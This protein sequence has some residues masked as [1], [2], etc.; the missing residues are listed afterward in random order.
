MTVQNKSWEQVG[1]SLEM[2]GTQLRRQIDHTRTVTDGD[3]AAFDKAVHALL[4]ALDDSI[5]A[6]SRLARDPV[7][8]EDLTEFGSSVR[9]A[10]VATFEGARDHVSTTVERTK[11]HL[12]AKEVPPA[13]PK[14]STRKR[15]P[16]KATVHR[17]PAAKAAP[18]RTPRAKAAAGKHT[19]G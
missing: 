9:D 8:R 17:A 1:K 5:Q 6:A 14:A 4:S 15:E 11:E 16:S 13:A 3:R 2:I 12:H 7:L 18:K 10:V 19:S